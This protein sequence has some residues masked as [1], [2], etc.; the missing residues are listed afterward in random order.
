MYDRDERES[1]PGECSGHHRVVAFILPHR[2]TYVQGIR[3]RNGG[4]FTLTGSRKFA[5]SGRQDTVRI[6]GFAP[7][8]GWSETSALSNFD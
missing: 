7:P 5:Q 2:F 3:I 1:W 4:N 6:K 8:S